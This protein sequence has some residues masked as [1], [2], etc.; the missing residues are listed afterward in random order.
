MR[1]CLSHSAF[2]LIIAIW[3][4]AAVACGAAPSAGGADTA[5]LTGGNATVAPLPESAG[6]SAPPAPVEP[7]PAATP[8]PDAP[9]VPPPPAGPPPPNRVRDVAPPAIRARAAVVV[10]G[11][12]GAVLYDNDAHTPLPPAS[13]TK[14]L[15]A[16]LALE[17]G[18]LNEEIEVQ[19]DQRSYWGSV[20]G[21]RNGDRFTLQ[22]LLYGL[23]LPSGND[24]AY[25]I[26]AHIAGSERDFAD[27]MNARMRQ[28]G[29]TENTFVNASGLGRDNSNLISANDLAQLARAA[30]TN[31]EFAALVKTKAWTARGSRAISMRNG[32]E[33]LYSYPG[34]DGVKI[35]FG[36]RSGGNTGV[37]SAVRNGRRLFVVVLNTPDRPGE[38]AALLDWA[39]ASFAWPNADSGGR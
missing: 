12:S 4:V 37:G 22:D 7:T 21:L 26:A 20:M 11:D 29:L 5:L 24:A 36:G 16:L 3:L 14:I 13:T 32:N 38:S 17:R 10:D 9:S 25:V 15:T 27:L 18:R 8:A 2:S 39:F 30:M 28:L 23:M 6:T 34:A 31:P 33:L 35:G 19:L 1:R